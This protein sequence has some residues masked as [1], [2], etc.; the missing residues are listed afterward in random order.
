MYWLIVFTLVLARGLLVCSGVVCDSGL[1][2]RLVCCWVWVFVLL[3]FD[4][5]LVCIVLRLVR[6]GVV[7]VFLL[8]V[9]LVCWLTILGLVWCLVSSLWALGS[10]CGLGD[11]DFVG[12]LGFALLFRVACF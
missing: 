6:V 2:F 5:V 11:L 1:G 7:A 10:L 3:S 9:W 4:R 8:F 12:Y